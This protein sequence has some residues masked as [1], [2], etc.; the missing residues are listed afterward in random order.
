MYGFTK[1]ETDPA[2]IN[3]LVLINRRTRSLH[4]DTKYEVHI[5]KKGLKD[6]SPGTS[7]QSRN[8]IHHK[9]TMH[10]YTQYPGSQAIA[11]SNI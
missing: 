11:K 3:S 5:E 1:Y 4:F 2:E 6:A 7:G 10:V 9:P 8:E